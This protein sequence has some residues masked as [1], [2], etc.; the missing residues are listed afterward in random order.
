MILDIGAHKG[1]FSVFAALKGAIVPAIEPNPKAYN[2]LI[3]NIELN[4]LACRIRLYNIAIALSD[5]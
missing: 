4:K 1:Y 3:K 5:G 2:V